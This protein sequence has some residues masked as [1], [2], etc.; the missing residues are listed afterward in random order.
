MI[1]IAKKTEDRIEK[2]GTQKCYAQTGVV[3]FEKKKQS[4][5]SESE[6]R[7]AQTEIVLFQKRKGS[8]KKLCSDRNCTFPEQKRK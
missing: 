4:E 5:K 1:N 3:I 2:N 8:E 6:K 7:F